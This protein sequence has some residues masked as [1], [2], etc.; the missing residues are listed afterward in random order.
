MRSC[1]PTDA[2]TPQGGIISPVLANWVLDG[3]E[4]LLNKKFKRTTRNGESMNLHVNFIRYADDFVITGGSKEQLEQDV[5]PLVE[6]FLRERGLELSAEKT[7]ITHIDDGFDFLGHNIRKYNGKLLIKP[8]Q[9]A[10]KTH[11]DEIRALVNANKTAKQE[12]LIKLLNPK[13][14]GGATTT[15]MGLPR[16]HSPGWTWNFGDYCGAGR[17]ADIQTKAAAG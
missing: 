5:K 10:Q 17:C 13:I 2:G 16:K 3:L 7:K 9:K 8:S 14:R 15:G 1:F 11:L 6:Q 4:G 12:H